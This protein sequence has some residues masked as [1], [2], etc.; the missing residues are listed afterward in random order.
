MQLELF[1]EQPFI[2]TANGTNLNLL[3]LY[4]QIKTAEQWTNIQLYSGW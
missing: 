4:G 3:T 2:R 1:L